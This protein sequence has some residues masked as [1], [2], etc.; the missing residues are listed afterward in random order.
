MLQAKSRIFEGTGEI[1]V[2]M[3]LTLVGI[4]DGNESYNSEAGI[5]LSTGYPQCQMLPGDKALQ[6][7]SSA[8]KREI[9]GCCISVCKCR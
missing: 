9:A 6:T 3:H 1:L 7:I 8:G 4:L 2:K 5:E